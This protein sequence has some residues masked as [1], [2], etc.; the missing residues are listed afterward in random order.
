MACGTC[1][2]E[3][4]AILRAKVQ[5]ELDKLAAIL[6]STGLFNR[7]FGVNAQYGVAD[8]DAALGL[9]PDP[10]SL[11]LLNLL[12]YLTCPLTPLAI[13]VAGI[14]VLTDQDPTAVFARLKALTTGKIDSARRSYE[15][16]L[17]SSSNNK[18]IEA[19]RKY[20]T[21]MLRVRFDAASFAEAVVIAASVQVI[22]GDSEFL[23]GPY[24]RFAQLANGFGF[25]GGVP[26]T[27]DQNLAALIQRLQRAEEKFAA[28][29]RSTI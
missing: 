21:N 11:N 27:L 4:T 7:A 16:A 13:G 29:R 5:I 10:V 20:L 8:A 12:N 9:I 2:V 22:C 24:Q 26:N 14:E 28:L 25:T 3:V 17:S 18:L 1:P 6:E 19:A 23:E 15:N